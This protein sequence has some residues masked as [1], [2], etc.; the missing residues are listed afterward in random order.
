MPLPDRL[1]LLLIA[2]MLLA[3]CG[4]NHGMKIG[5]IKG[6]QWAEPGYDVG[7]DR[8]ARNR[9]K[10]EE[11]M[12]VVGDRFKRGELDDAMKFARAA[13]KL[14]PKAPD[15]HTAQAV[16]ESRRGQVVAAGEAYRKAAELA[17][18]R[19]DVLNNYGTWLCGNGHPAEAL[20]WFDRAMAD[21]EYDSRA[22][23][24][25]NA[26]GCALDAGQSERAQADLRQALA[27]APNNPYA[28]ESMARNE[29]LHG[30][31]FEARAFYQ[32]RLAA[33]PATVSVLQ[34]AIQVEE[35]LGD[36]T[37]AGRF[38]Q[39]LREEFPSDAASNPQG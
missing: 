28:L 11:L 13:Q 14:D 32:R 33:A 19:G 15:P 30:R 8:K 2:A 16:I 26:G 35:R 17:P 39:R 6:E 18:R 10:Y 12:T 25:A 23:A 38:Q 5:K 4:S 22:E 1:L 7:D 21:P 36:R 29:V 27:L 34:L 37:A 3:G 24:L 9:V 31:Y 20:V